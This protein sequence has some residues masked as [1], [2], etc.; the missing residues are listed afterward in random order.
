MLRDRVARALHSRRWPRAVLLRRALAGL[1]L[2]FATVLALLPRASAASPGV[3]VLVARH[4]LGG[5]IRL[6]ARDL[7]LR[8][9]PADLAPEGVLHR[10]GQANGRLLIGGVRR[11]EPITDVHIAG[12]STTALISGDPGLVSVPVRLSD[13][14]VAGLLRPGMRVG[15][16]GTAGA[17]DGPTDHTASAGDIS[18][19]ATDATVIT[20]TAAESDDQRQGRL[21]VLAMKADDATRVA[22]ASLR[23]AVTVTLR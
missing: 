2:A 13:P 9:M 1:L 23:H 7:T 4:D 6:A 21:V 17:P 10:T 14:A 19:T 11:G 22:A 20:V 12:P 5:G 8:E 15:V 16:L 3:A 18:T